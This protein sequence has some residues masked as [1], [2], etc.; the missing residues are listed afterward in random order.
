MTESRDMGINI[1]QFCTTMV[2]YLHA[3]NQKKIMNSLQDIQRKINEK[4]SR[5]TNKRS[6]TDT[7]GDKADQF[8]FISFSNIIP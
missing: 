4:I 3:K 5:W 2:P 7:Q 8:W 1:C 6:K